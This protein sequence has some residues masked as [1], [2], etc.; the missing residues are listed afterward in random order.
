MTAPDSV[1]RKLF[2][3]GLG[4]VVT[5]T[6]GWTGYWF[7]VRP[8]LER[9]STGPGSSNLM[10][11]DASD[12]NL[13]A[14]GEPLYAANCAACHGANLE[15]QAD[16][17]RRLPNGRLPAPPHDETGHT[18]HHPDSVLFDITK[19]G[20]AA[21]LTD[22]YETDMGG[23]ENSLTDEEIRAVIAY[24]KSRWPDS[25]RERHRRLNEAAQQ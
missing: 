24:I 15:G 9:S 21:L 1:Y 23:Y 7:V 3:I 8:N 14:M 18:W 19:Y 22:S 12:H 5:A 25:I 6:L 2:L 20:T 17:Q 13:V 11:I 16:W 4:V 10:R